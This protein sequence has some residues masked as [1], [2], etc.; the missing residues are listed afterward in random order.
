MIVAGVGCRKDAP[1]ASFADALARALDGR[2]DV[3]ALA[4][5]TDKAEALRPFAQM[6]GLRLIAVAQDA[7]Q[8]VDTATKSVHS[9]QTK[10]VDSVAEATALA[11]AGAKARLIAPRVVSADRMVTC[12]IAQGEG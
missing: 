6:R 4:T 12:A 3:D 11:A 9:Q 7:A 2:W 1:E 10:S 8:Q 5:L